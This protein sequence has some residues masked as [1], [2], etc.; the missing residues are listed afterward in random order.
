MALLVGHSIERWVMSGAGS[1]L[2][3][4]DWECLL[5]RTG[6]VLID[7]LGLI[8]CCCVGIVPEVNFSIKN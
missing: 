4:F 2:R 7:I 3:D 5:V 1:L 8:S 6:M